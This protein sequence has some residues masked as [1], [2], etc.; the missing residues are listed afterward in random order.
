MTQGLPQARGKKESGRRAGGGRDARTETSASA[1][2]CDRGRRREQRDIRGRGQA[3]GD[4]G[5]MRV[6]PK[7]TPPRTEDWLGCY[8]SASVLLKSEQRV[9]MKHKTQKT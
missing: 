9:K 7:A 6:T 5:V 2:L 8:I 1:L 4:G 3:S